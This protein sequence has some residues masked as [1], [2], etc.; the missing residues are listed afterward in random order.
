MA[1][2]AKTQPTKESLKSYLSRIDDDAR[3]KDCETVAAIMEKET[4]EKPVLW[5]TG[6]VGF[7][8][9]TYKYA[10]GQSGD[11]PIIAFAS[12]KADITLYV[13]MGLDSVQELLKK[14][15]KHKSSKACLYIKRLSDV[16][17][18]TL[19]AIVKESVKGME[20]QR[21]R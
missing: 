1:T 15:G 3:R 16:D 12:R 18:P 21:V 19:K 5:G 11:W 13:M 7:G 6:I 9:Y 8:K 4:G 10:S 20:P 2:E 14:L 17:M